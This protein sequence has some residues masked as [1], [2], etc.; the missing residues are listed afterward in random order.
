MRCSMSTREGRL[1][2]ICTSH[3]ASYIFEFKIDATAETALKQIHT[4]NYAAPFLLQKKNIYLIGVNF[5]TAEKKINDILVEKWNGNA[6]LRLEGA[7]TPKEV[8]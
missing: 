7:F 4:K 3:K 8:K 6:F 2:T 5:I 1:D